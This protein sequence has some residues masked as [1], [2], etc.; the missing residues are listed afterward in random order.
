MWITSWDDVDEIERLSRFQQKT[1]VM[2]FSMELA[3][4]EL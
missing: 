1:M 2:I 4:T 3:N